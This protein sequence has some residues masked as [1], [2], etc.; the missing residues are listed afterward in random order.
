MHL[1]TK[2]DAYDAGRGALSAYLCGVARN[3]VRRHVARTWASLPEMPDENDDAL[4]PTAW[5]DPIT[6]AD[7]LLQ[8]E[9][10]EQLRRAILRLPPHYRDVL[11][12]CELQECSYAEAAAICGCELGT[13]RSRLSRARALLTN[14]M[15]PALETATPSR[16]RYGL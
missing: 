12:L 6:P 13:V 9:A 10:S 3:F 2:A 16:E 4:Y 5:I 7:R 1:L 14:D 15:D 8:R 11:V